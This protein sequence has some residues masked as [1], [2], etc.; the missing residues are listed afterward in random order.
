M[1]IK[2]PKGR[3]AQDNP[4]NRFEPRHVEPYDEDIYPEDVTD[5]VPTTYLA[6]ASKSVLTKN[7]SPDVGFRYS[8]NPYSGCAHG[9]SYCYAR[10][11]HEYWGM[12]AGLD[13]ESKILI[14]EDSAKLLREALDK[15]SYEPDIIAMSGVTDCYQPG[16]R[17]FEL[18]RQCLKVLAEYK[19]P[20]GLITKNR[21]VTR[22]ID[23]LSEM[24]AWGG[25]CVFLSITTLD[26]E[27]SGKLEPRASRPQA[28]L[29]TISR[30]AEAG[31]P[32]GVNA[33]PMI[34][35]LTDSELPAIIAAAANAGATFSGYT[36]V[37]LPGAVSGIFEAWLQKNVPNSASKVMN[38][39]RQVHGGNVA[40]S[41]FGTRMK[42]DGLYAEQVRALY[43]MACRKA[44]LGSAPALSTEHFK[45]PERG[46]L[47]LFA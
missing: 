40:D 7:D 2:N 8:V 30:L 41:R 17:Q 47:D 14:K 26:P 20:A 33:A 38:H 25:V 13:F 3:G 12:S 16:E 19:N 18:T 4:G 34:P 15:P 29:E 9:C 46:Q 32:V 28:R 21:L 45:R 31:I 37:R 5:S 36:I 27:L 44:G 22:D 24:A 39:I 1:I 42:G 6:V 35:G 11:Y 10:P 43:K 23:I